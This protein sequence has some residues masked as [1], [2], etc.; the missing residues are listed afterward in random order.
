M[1]TTSV[2]DYVFKGAAISWGFPRHEIAA[3]MSIGN[4][5]PDILN[6]L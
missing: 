2:N 3:D 4:R 5:V 6:A 1:K